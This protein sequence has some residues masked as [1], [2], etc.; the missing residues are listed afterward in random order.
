MNA[1]SS[2]H[3][4]IALVDV[5]TADSTFYR[6]YHSSEST[7]TSGRPRLVV[8]YGAAT[9]AP[10]PSTSNSKGN[11]IL[12]RFPWG[13]PARYELAYE[14]TVALGQVTVNGRNVTV[15]STHLDPESGTRRIT[16]TKQ[17]PAWAGNFA[18]NRVIAGDM[19]AQPSSTEM[20][21]IKKTYVDAWANAK[22][23]GIAFSA[24]DNPYG[25]TRRSRIDF[26]FTSKGASSLVLK[27]VEVVDT[28]DSS[29]LMPSDHRPILTVYEVR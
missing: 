7:D 8:T 28:R 9:A 6:R 11:M 15:M 13:A 12:S 17:L 20:N 2:R 10:A 23:R 14:R 16:Q 25:Y 5:Q 19:N 24:P 3:T 29:G 22:S 1:G 21:E 26:V 27:R 4:R 18:E